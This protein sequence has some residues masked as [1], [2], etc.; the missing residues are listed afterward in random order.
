[1]KLARILAPLALTLPAAAQ[2]DVRPSVALQSSSDG[3]APFVTTDGDLSVA[4]LKQQ[5]FN[6][7]SLV[8][9]DGR[10]VEWSSQVAIDPANDLAPIQYEQAVIDGDD[11]VVLWA[12]GRFQFPFGPAAISR[13]PFVRIFDT[14]TQ[15]FGPEIQVP[16]QSPLSE[17]ESKGMHLAVTEV[18]GARRILV[19][20]IQGEP[21][22]P[23][24]GLRRIAVHATSD[25][26]A[27]W[28]QTFAQPLP[29]PAYGDLRLFAEGSDVH[30][31]WSAPEQVQGFEVFHAR[32]TDGG[33]TFGP[34]ST[35][36]GA[37]FDQLF[38]VDVQGGV[39]ALAWAAID[40]QT[41]T[42]QVERTS[43]VD[44]GATWAPVSMLPQSPSATFDTALSPELEIRPLTGEITLAALALESGSQKLVAQ[45]SPD[46]GATWLPTQQVATGSAVDIDLQFAGD[47]RTRGALT[48]QVDVGDELHTALTLDGGQSFGP[49]QTVD[50]GLLDVHATWNDR[51]QNLILT[52]AEDAA[53]SPTSVS[54][55]RPQDLDLTGFTAGSTS[56]QVDFGNMDGGAD[57]ALVFLSVATGNLPL[58][59][60]GRNTG[61]G[62]SPLLQNTLPLA[63]GGL[64][65]S[66]LTAG[67]GSTGA[68]PLANGVPAG[69]TIYALG[70]SLD[71]GTGA[72]VDL[73]DV[74]RIDT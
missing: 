62:D 8:R 63:V 53:F 57:L 60:D 52:R 25:D 47:G 65:A 4:I 45:H 41:Q 74:I 35:V 36:P 48:W 27:N 37:R 34:A 21:I 56:V 23:S 40:P 13:V 38:D 2:L 7:L 30:V 9:S 70:L 66:P 33:L 69:L 61:L 31:F 29:N 24:S 32:S 71:L 26:G 11:V 14:A 73:T 72:F 58:P 64:L 15:T 1:M 55:L 12:D 68:L 3:T 16:I 46:A 42:I 6:D 67:T 17:V 39:L 18:G 59:I 50:V 5:F 22:G 43:S 44:G 20:S 54:G 49:I 28:Q 10:G 19:A 51:Y